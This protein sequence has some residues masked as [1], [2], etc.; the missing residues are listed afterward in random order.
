[1]SWSKHSGNISRQGESWAKFEMDSFEHMPASVKRD[2]SDFTALQTGETKKSKFIPLGATES[3]EDAKQK[4]EMLEQ[5][6]YTKGFAQGEKDG[7]ELGEKKAE[8]VIENIENLFMELCRLKQDILNQSE[9]EILEII[10]AIAKKVVHHQISFD[11]GIIKESVL[12][13]LQLAVE[14]SKIIFSVSPEDYDYVERLR[15]E[16][17]SE[18]KELKSIIITSDPKISRGGC[19]LETPHG[20]VDA[21]I[22]TQLE[23]IYQF[24]EEAFN[25]EKYD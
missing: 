9:K 6:G 14:K 16:L 2:S 20:D 21:T 23:R 25:E 10:F 18:F 22:E 17:F 12:K 1:M 8:K 11:E 15:P 13:A 7:F 4:K 5:E 19:I 24:L 3:D